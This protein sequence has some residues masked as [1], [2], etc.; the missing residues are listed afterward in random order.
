MLGWDSDIYVYPPYIFQHACSLNKDLQ[1]AL[2]QDMLGQNYVEP[3]VAPVDSKLKAF[4]T[5][6]SISSQD[7]PWQ[8]STAPRIAAACSAEV[9]AGSSKSWK[10]EQ[11]KQ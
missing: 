6:S 1:T 5:C 9:L 7:K 2:L 8:Q 11:N 10:L 4:I 3:P